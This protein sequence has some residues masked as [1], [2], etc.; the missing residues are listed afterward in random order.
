VYSVHLS[1]SPEAKAV[2]IRRDE[3]HQKPVSAGGKYRSRCEYYF[4]TID[5][6]CGM[7]LRASPMRRV[8]RE[9]FRAKK[10]LIAVI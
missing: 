6:F 7:R 3:R 10:K 2:A 5:M 4:V 8:S 9:K 1:K